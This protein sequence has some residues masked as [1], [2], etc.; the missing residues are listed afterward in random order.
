MVSGNWT[1]EA[2]RQSNL[3]AP[4]AGCDLPINTS[5]KRAGEM[6]FSFVFLAEPMGCFDFVLQLGVDLV[7]A[8]D[9]G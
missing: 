3:A 2:D 4:L 9:G 5:R 7:D 6:D 8:D 1:T